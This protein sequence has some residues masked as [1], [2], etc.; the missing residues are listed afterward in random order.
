MKA[1]SRAEDQ[2]EGL[3]ATAEG[4]GA[5]EAVGPNHTG[6]RVSGQGIWI[7]SYEQQ[8]RIRRFKVGS[9]YSLTG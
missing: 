8:K 2:N 5:G 3:R 4:A 7:L 9:K 1:L 6:P